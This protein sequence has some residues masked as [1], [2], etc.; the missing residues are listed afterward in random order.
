MIKKMEKGEERDE[1]TNETTKTEVHED[2]KKGG[3]FQVMGETVIKHS[4]ID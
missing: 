3:I 2:E 4:S 1:T